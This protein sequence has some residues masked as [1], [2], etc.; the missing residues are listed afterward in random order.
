MLSDSAIRA[1]FETAID[2]ILC[3][4]QTTRVYGPRPDP[5]EYAATFHRS[6]DTFRGWVKVGRMYKLGW[7]KNETIGPSSELVDVERYRDEI[8]KRKERNQRDITMR[9]R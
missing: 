7:D 8:K 9:V 3:P 1:T 5:A 6:G 4:G 2:F